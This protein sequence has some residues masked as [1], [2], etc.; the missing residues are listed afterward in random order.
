MPAA[1][2]PWTPAAGQVQVLSGEGGGEKVVL[3]MTLPEGQHRTVRMLMAR[4]GFKVH[5]LRRVG[6]GPL[7]LK[8]LGSGHWRFLTPGEVHGLKKSGSL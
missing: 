4:L 5:R 2:R 6:I 8:G 1:S 3:R 7:R